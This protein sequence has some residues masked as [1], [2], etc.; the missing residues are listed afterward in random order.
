MNPTNN[1]TDSGFFRTQDLIRSKQKKYNSFVKK[2]DKRKN[3]Q[4]KLPWF[5]F[6]KNWF[7]KQLIFNIRGNY[8]IQKLL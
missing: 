5:L 2:L 8:C 7:K 3:T 1:M 4:E 6:F